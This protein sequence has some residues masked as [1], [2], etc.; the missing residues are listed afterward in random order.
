MCADKLALIDKDLLVRLLG[1]AS[2]SPPV[3]PTLREINSIDAQLEETLDKKHVD[4]SLRVKEI[5]RLIST[6]NTHQNNYENEGTKVPNVKGPSDIWAEKTIDASPSRFQ[7]TAKSL[8]DHIKK[9]GRL[10]WNER[11]QL[12]IDGLSVPDSNILDLVHSVTRPRKVTAPVGAKEFISALGDINTPKELIPNVNALKYSPSA[13]LKTVSGKR[14]WIRVPRKTTA[15]PSKKAPDRNTPV[16]TRSRKLQKAPY[17]ASPVSR[18]G[19]SETRT[20]ISVRRRREKAPGRTDIESE[21]DF[22]T[23]M[24][25]PKNWARYKD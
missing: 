3:N 11:G 2:P 12:V 6:H 14:R 21:D 7:R 19:R 15:T 16:Q 20:P 24:N 9:S 13:K 8:L 17:S 18:R 10:D 22:L 4:P 25:L 5:N 23:P 1:R